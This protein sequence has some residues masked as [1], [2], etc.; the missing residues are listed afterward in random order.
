MWQLGIAVNVGMCETEACQRQ[1]HRR[2]HHQSSGL[3][4]YS[5][6]N[7]AETKDAGSKQ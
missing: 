2:F 7:D 6:D 3:M 5:C 4:V 1:L